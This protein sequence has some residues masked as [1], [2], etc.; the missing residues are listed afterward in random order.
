M[1]QHL[2]GMERDGL[3]AQSV[4]RPTGGRPEQLYVLGEKGRELFPR[5][6][7]WFS[8]LL[9]ESMRD[10]AG[11]CRPERAPRRHGPARRRSVARPGRRRR[12]S[13]RSA[14]PR[15]PG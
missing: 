14:W 2:A 4:T 1:R 13:R 12:T 11:H 5:H 15:W 7:S 8:Q 10:E 9:I 3:V 6:Y